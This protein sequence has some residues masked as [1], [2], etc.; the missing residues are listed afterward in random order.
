M[1]RL[2]ACTAQQFA[3]AWFAAWNAHAVQA[4]GAHYA[5]AVQYESPFVARLGLNA[6]GVLRGKEAVM[7]YFARA[8]GAYPDL[9]FT[10]GELYLGENSVVLR[11]QSVMNL[12]A[13]ELFVFDA[14]GKAARVYC[15]YH[16]SASVTP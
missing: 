2:D 9:K 1:S 12:Q 6:D 11:Y 13:A 10:P 4:I 16:A 3:D 14:S 7:A 8:L 15:H 5:D